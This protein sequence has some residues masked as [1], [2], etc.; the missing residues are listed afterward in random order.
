[1]LRLVSPST[2]TS[3]VGWMLTSAAA[4]I[5]AMRN[6]A[7]A[8]PR[9]SRDEDDI[10]SLQSDVLIQILA[11]ADLAEPK[12]QDLLVGAGPADDD[13]VVQLGERR[14]AARKAQCL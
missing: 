6:R 8:A 2:P 12:G 3:A 10:A 7:A 5:R 11:R 14:P 1:M 9:R 4:A 13:D